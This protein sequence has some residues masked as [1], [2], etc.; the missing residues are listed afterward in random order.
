MLAKGGTVGFCP[1]RSAFLWFNYTALEGRMDGL[2]M[3]E[4][5]WDTANYVTGFAIAQVIYTTFSI[6]TGDLKALHGKS[7]HV[8]ALIVTGLF[9]AGYLIAIVWC[10]MN[11]SKFDDRHLKVWRYVGWARVIGVVFFT[12][13][14]IATIIGHWRDEYQPSF[15]L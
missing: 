7:A 5:L 3:A 2:N 10:G 11:G 4:K 14:L 1:P 8:T 12:F 13:I 6:A 9:T 15:E